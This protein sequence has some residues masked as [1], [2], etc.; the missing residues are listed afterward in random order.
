MRLKLYHDVYYWET[1]P[2]F[3]RNT[4]RVFKWMN[5]NFEV[6]IATSAFLS[7][8][9]E[10]YVGKI[11]WIKRNLP[12]YDIGK[13]IYSH[14]KYDLRGDVIIEDVPSQ[15]EKFIGNKIIMNAGWNENF[16][17]E[18]D[19]LYRAFCWNDIKKILNKLR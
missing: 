9:E 12:W 3:D 15:V 1:L 5:E 19:T 6:R 18:N 10:C 7:G 14:M 13:V 11:R 4:E 16:N 17:L 8:A 2:F